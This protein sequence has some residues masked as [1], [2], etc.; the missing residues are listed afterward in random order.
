MSGFIISRESPSGTVSL[1]T[2]GSIGVVGLSRDILDGSRSSFGSCGRSEL[3]GSCINGCPGI[4]EVSMCGISGMII[5][6][7]RIGSLKSS[8]DHQSG[9]IVTISG[10]SGIEKLAVVVSESSGRTYEEIVGLIFV[11]GGFRC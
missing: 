8:V 6:C 9:G 4:G 2:V 10:I 7:S 3:F 11:V 1:F 5:R